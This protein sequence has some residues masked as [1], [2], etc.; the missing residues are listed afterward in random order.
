MT[1][2]SS[3]RVEVGAGAVEPGTAE[4]GSLGVALP[5]LS[6]V[7]AHLLEPQDCLSRWI[8]WSLRVRVIRHNSRVPSPR[9]SQ[10]IRRL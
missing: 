10:R 4:P 9:R 1:A 5:A 2:S 6:C 7:V 8:L 3:L